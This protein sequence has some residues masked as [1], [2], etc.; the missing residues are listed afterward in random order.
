MGRFNM[1]STV[2]V[3]LPAGRAAWEVRLAAET[4]VQVGSRIGKLIR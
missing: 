3:V 1:G 4:P 2:I